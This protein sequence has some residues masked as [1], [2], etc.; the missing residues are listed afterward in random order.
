VMTQTRTNARRMVERLSQRW[1][2]DPTVLIIGA[3]R[4]GTSY[5]WEA[6]QRHDEVGMSKQKEVHYFTLRFDRGYQWYKSNFPV[7]SPDRT[8]A[9]EA[10]PYYLFHPLAA[11]RAA[12][13]LPWAKVIVLLRD[14]VD[15]A[16]SHYRHNIR[17]GIET[18]S[19]VAAFAAEGDR[20]RGEEERIQADPMYCSYNYQHFSYF[21][22]G[23]Y[24]EQLDRWYNGFP[25]E[26]I[27]VGESEMLFA[28]PDETIGS[29]CDFLGISRRVEIP[30]G[31]R[32]DTAPLDIPAALAETL[33]AQYTE[34]NARLR[35]LIGK[36]FLWL[37][38]SQSCVASESE[39]KPCH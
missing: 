36:K 5:V 10:T 8:H 20:L 3:Q 28:R 18:L 15:R 24:A 30:V 16:F 6:L 7:R 2:S 26:S 21:R 23:L 22:R 12:Q 33:R 37:D 31:S 13:T 1:R 17:L 29:I 35:S 11:K 27:W 34:A 39:V 32:N 9:G 4:A 25:T 14:P 19:P 38:E